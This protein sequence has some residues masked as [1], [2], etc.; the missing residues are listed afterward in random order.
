MTTTQETFEK[1]KYLVMSNVVSE[2][3]CK[4]LVDRLFSLYDQGHLYKDEQCPKSDSIYGDECLDQLLEMLADPLSEVIGRKLVPTYTY[5]RIYRPGEVLEKHIDRP[6][7]ELSATLTLGYDSDDG[8][9]P[10]FFDDER[11]IEVELDVGELAFYKGAE[12]VH[13]REEFTGKWHVQVF[14]HY[15][16]ADGPY[17]ETNKYDGRNKLSHHKKILET[18][19][20]EDIL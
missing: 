12:V 6:S 15:V 7:C 18:S 8:I 16:D 5:A 17:A 4:N 19:G 14:L 3:D 1:E 13:W 9:W 2:E 20:T 10:I 11:E